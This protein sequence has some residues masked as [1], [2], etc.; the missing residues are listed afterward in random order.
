[1]AKTRQRR[2]HLA[3]AFICLTLGAWLL[4]LSRWVVTNSLSG[5]RDSSPLVYAIYGAYL[6][7][8]GLLLLGCGV[9]ALRA[10][11]GD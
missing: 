1:V 9:V 7:L 5:E 6:W 4:Y 3:R 8:P 10:K 11:N 2:Q